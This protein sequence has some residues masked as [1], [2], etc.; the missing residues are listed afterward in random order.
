MAVSLREKCMELETI[1]GLQQAIVTRVNILTI[2]ETVTAN[3][4]TMRLT[5]RRGFGRAA[6]F[7]LHKLPNK[8][9]NDLLCAIARATSTLSI[10]LEYK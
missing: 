5:S 10:L 3:I 2:S 7:S 1:F 6:Y 4:S 8:Q 9:L